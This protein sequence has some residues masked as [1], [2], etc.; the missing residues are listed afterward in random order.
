MINDHA[1]VEFPIRPILDYNKMV[2]SIVT[3]ADTYRKIYIY[4]IYNSI[5]FQKLIRLDFKDGI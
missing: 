3:N 2:P 5:A 1:I 4:V